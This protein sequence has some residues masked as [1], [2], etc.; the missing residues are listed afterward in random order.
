MQINV[1]QTSLTNAVASNRPAIAQGLTAPESLRPVI[2]QDA[3]EAASLDKPKNAAGNLQS[4]L[5][6]HLEYE[7]DTRGHQGAIA[8]YLQTQHAAKR[9]EIQQMVGVDLYA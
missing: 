9:D 2:E 8:Q 1:N 3:V 7:Q 5:G 6:A 4:R